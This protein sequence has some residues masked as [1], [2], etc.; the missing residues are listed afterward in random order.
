[1]KWPNFVMLI[2]H[3]TSA[4]NV[5]KETKAADRTYQAFLAAFKRNPDDPETVRLAREIQGRFA[6]GMGDAKTPLADKDGEQAFKTGV[7]LR[8][9]WQRVP[10]VIF[11]S[12]YHRTKETLRHIMRGWPELESVKVYEDERI[13]EQEHGL[14]L[15]YNDWRVF[16]T[17]HPEQRRL[18]ELEGAYWYRYPQGENVPDVKER[19]RS[20]VNT[21]V[22][23]F[24]GQGVLAITHHLNILAIRAIF[25]R[26]SAEKFMHVDRVE[27]PINCG[28]T[29]YVGNPGLGRD[30]RLILH[31]YNVKHY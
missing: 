3:D 8:T 19:N 24:D 9:N 20:W 1:M 10:H 4:Y 11:V 25:E 2:R 16:H 7:S 14:S 5:L 22:R 28:V 21:I 6:L 23:D 29:T 17:L 26:W 30:G 13:R 31:T 12:P 15:L 27:K 18:Y